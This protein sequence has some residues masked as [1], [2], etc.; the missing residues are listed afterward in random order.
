MKKVSDLFDV[1]YGNSL[2]LNRLF[3]GLFH[4]TGQRISIYEENTY[5]T[6]QV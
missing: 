3:T 4:Q 6:G 5:L 1:A 2:E